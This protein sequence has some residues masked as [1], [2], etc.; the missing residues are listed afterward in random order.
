MR[1]HITL[2]DDLVRELDRRIGARRRSGFIA[3]AV[4][5]ALDDERRWELIES[6]FGSIGA[7]SHAWDDD[8]ASWVREQRRVDERRVG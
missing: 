4:E 8:P 5:A 3:R 6:S 1:L 2:Q 7:E